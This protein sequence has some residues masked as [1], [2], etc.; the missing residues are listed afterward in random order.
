MSNVAT[1]SRKVTISGYDTP[2]LEWHTRHS[3]DNPIATGT[4]VLPTPMP[5]HVG[6]AAQVKVEA[7]YN[8]QFFTEFYG[9]I[10]D[11][12][13]T[14]D[15]DG[16]SVRLA[17][18]GWAKRLWLSQHQE[19]VVPGIQLYSDIFRALCQRQYVPLFF[20]DLS[21]NPTGTYL[22]FGGNSQVNGG[23]TI[24]S[25]DS[26]PGEVADRLGRLYGYRVYD[27]PVGVVRL[28]KISGLPNPAE[29]VRVYTEGV[30]ILS[31][32]KSRTLAGMVNYWEIKGARYTATDGA[33]VAVRSIPATVPSDPRLGPTGVSRKSIT[34]GDIVTNA[35]A[36][37]CRNVQEI[38]HSTPR[39]YWSWTI[40]GDPELSPGHVVQLN[41]PTIGENATVW[42]MSVAQD[43]V[44]GSWTTSLEGWAGAGMALP[45]GNDCAYQQ[46]VGTS[47]FHIG[48]ETL[49]HYRRPAADGTTKVIPFSVANGYS[50]LTIRGYGHGCN[51]FVANAAS[52]A[53]RFE[54]WQAGAKVAEGEMPRLNENFEQQLNYGND[55]TWDRIVVPLSGSL[56]AG[57]AEL[58]I[59]AGYD[60]AVGDIDDF[61]CRNLILETCGVGAPIVI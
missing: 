51:S 2:V 13:I 44:D 28:K 14:F 59:I 5:G 30:N 31:I 47:G 61:E 11:D 50:T 34:D 19:I 36:D 9:Q 38:D 3:V 10:A 33:D 35:R 22:Y 7:G 29:T 1:V 54:I 8:G 46:L 20:A 15:D 24:V 58:R 39:V 41:S 53:S 49:A 18:E 43:Y 16:G 60:S 45:A 56:A 42:V 21:T 40:V 57:A 4:L 26:T 23:N 48:N 27:T 25:A 52:T 55:A 32:G 37:Q 12:G 17:L 6:P